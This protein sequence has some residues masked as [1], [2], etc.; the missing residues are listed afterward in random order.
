MGY[1]SRL[2]SYALRHRGH[3]FGFLAAAGVG[4][5]FNVISPLVLV[6]IIDSLIPAPTITG[7]ELFNLAVLYVSLT[8]GYMGFDMVGRY[9]AALLAQHVIYDLRAE[10]YDSLMEKDLAFYDENETGQLLA[11]VTTDV[12]TMREF[13]FW[14]YRVIFVGLATMFGTYLVMW[15][16]S[17]D[18]TMFMFILIPFTAFFIAVFSKKVRPVFYEARSQYGVLSSVLTENIVGMKVV[19]SYA[20][21]DREYERVEKENRGFLELRV[22]ALRLLSF[23]RPLLP[24]VFGITTGF[25]I[26]LGGFSFLLGDLSYGVFVGFLSLVGMLILPARFLAWGVGMYQRASAAGERTFYILD[27]RD[28][29]MNPETPVEKDKIEGRVDFDDVFFSYRGGNFILRDVDLHVEPG[30]VVALLGGTGSGKTSLI[31]LIPRFYDVDGYGTVSHQGRT[32]RASEKGT[33]KIGEQVH[34]IEHDSVEIES[35]S[36]PVK[37]P[38]RVRVDGIDVRQMRIDQLRKSI[39]MVHQDPFLFSA[40]IRENIA[41]GRP[42]ASLE[43]VEA[44]AKAAMIHEFV[45]TLDEGYDAEIGE[46]GVTLSGGQKQRIAIARALVANPRI[47]ILDDSTSSVDA[48]TEMMIQQA[49]ENLMEGRTTFIITHRLSTIRNADLIVMMERGRIVEMGSHE[50]LVALGGLYANI[51]GT[52]TEMEAAAPALESPTGGENE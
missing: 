11:R 25:L 34:R 15:S 38:G 30:Q 13:L 42:E 47:L 27:H 17:P 33:V 52:L 32:Y 14:G 28:D 4:T 40:S 10:L 44:A 51:H 12:T 3:F 24:T 26:Y 48:K 29:I 31:N 45:M 9:V 43:E 20:A 46:R 41:F 50:E 2:T 49:L 8:A 5:I 23:Y 19:Q 35:E 36:L 18:L 22:E 37:P 1:V 7:N 6:Q 39:G 16:L 21:G